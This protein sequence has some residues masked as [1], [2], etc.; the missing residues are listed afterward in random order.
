METEQYIQEQLREWPTK[1]TTIIIA[2]RVSSVMHADKIVIIEKGQITEEG[3]HRELMQNPN[4]YYYKTC[5]LQHGGI[6]E[7]G[8]A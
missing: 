5:M 1:A 8:E 7:G 6:E 2:Q 4:G 3:S